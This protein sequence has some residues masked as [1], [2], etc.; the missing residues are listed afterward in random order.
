MQSDKSN[1]HLMG[2]YLGTML[3]ATNRR[4][5]ITEIKT[6]FRRQL[7][8]PTAIKEPITASKITHLFLSTTKT[9]TNTTT[10]S[11][12]NKEK[13]KMSTYHSDTYIENSMY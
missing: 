1:F 13:K 8:N 10:K 2:F 12:Y 9:T 5:N 7:E 4:T 11:R 6:R 3:L